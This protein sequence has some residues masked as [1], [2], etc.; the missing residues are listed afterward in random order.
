MLK[1]LGVMYKILL[2]PLAMLYGLVIYVRNYLFD[3]GI[4]KSVSFNRAVIC[5]GN[6]TVGG[7]GKTPHIEYLVSLLRN[8][9]KISTLSRGYKRKTKGF[10]LA[11]QQSNASQIGDEPFQIFSKFANIKVAVDEKRVRGINS[12]LELHPDIEVVLLDDAFQ[13]RYVK[14]GL[15]ILL[16]DYNNLVTK[17]FFLPLGTLRDSVSQLHRADI[18]IVTKCPVNM[19]PIDQRIVSKELNLYP[20]Q[21]IYFTKLKYGDLRPV[22]SENLTEIKVERNLVTHAV[23]GIANPTPFFDYL[24]QKTKLINTLALTD[25]YNFTEKKIKAIFEKFSIASNDK[26]IIVTT[27][28]DAMRLKAFNGLPA[29]IKQSLYYIPIEIEFLNGLADDFNNKIRTYVRKS[30][31]NH[32]LHSK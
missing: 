28:K 5:I 26:R 11:N 15:S 17:D 32:G 3:I 27:E 21:N 18:V 9:F 14:P 2:A 8:D 24:N 10:L 12:L 4:L 29:E 1:T 31:R 16:V 23:A 6:L 19:K 25:H 22:F 7:T 30:K 20:Y 13:H